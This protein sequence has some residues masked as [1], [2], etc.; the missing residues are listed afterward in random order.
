VALTLLTGHKLREMICAGAARIEADKADIDALNVF[1]VPD[2]DTGTNMSLTMA[3]CAREVAACTSDAACDVANAASTGAL[4]GAR[5]NS[6]VIL[7]Q[8]MRGFAKACAGKER[9]TPADFIACLKAGADMAYKA[10]MK[11]R[12]GT[13]LTVARVIAEDLLASPAPADFE[14][15]LSALIT[16]GERILRKTP[17]ML[18]VLKQA[19]VVDSGGKGLL[20]IYLGYKM[21]LDGVAMELDESFAV[22]PTVAV[23]AQFDT[24]IE[25]GYCT[26]FFV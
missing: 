13:I 4:K 18:P 12:E 11:P 6:G 21:S 23:G 7:S 3:S 16:S 2:G 17:D 24:D 20:T 5:G 26:E 25:F 14:S 1:P 8:L 15:L 10:V 9:L 22:A 19:G